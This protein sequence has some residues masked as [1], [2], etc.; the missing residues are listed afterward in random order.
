MLDELASLIWSILLIIVILVLAYLFTRFVAGRS[1]G[2]ILRY[3]G[4]RITVLE[5]VTVGKDQKILLVK[6]GEHYYFL[7][8]AQGGI[9]CLEQ[10]SQE[11]SDRW[12]QESEAQKANAQE[13][14]FREALKKVMDSRRGKGGT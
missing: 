7:G 12:N 8:C 9:S 2:G 14:S 5:K 11:E 13:M 10:V 6:M 4:R 3:R 1:G